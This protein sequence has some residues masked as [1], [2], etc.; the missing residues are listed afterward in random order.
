MPESGGDGGRRQE[1]KS[2]GWGDLCKAWLLLRV[3]WEPLEGSEQ[4]TGGSDSCFEKD[5]TDF[6]QGS[7]V[8]AERPVRKLL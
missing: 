2:E 3:R 6:P 1:A 4:R 7:R 5:P 8:E